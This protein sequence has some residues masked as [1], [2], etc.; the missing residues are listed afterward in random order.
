MFKATRQGLGTFSL[1]LFV[2]LLCSG[3][4]AEAAR[5]AHEGFPVPSIVNSI[6]S[7]AG[8][9]PVALTAT[10]VQNGALLTGDYDVFVIGLNTTFKGASALYVQQVGNFIAAGGNIVTEYS[11]AG[12]FLSAYSSDVQPLTVAATPQ[13]RLFDA[14]YH[15]G[16]Y[17]RTGMPI[18][19]VDTASPVV[20]GL[21][22]PF[23]DGSATEYFY[24][25]QTSDPHLH[26]VGTFVGTGTP[27]FPLGQNLP[28][29]VT[30]C[31]GGSTF[32][33]A[34]CDWSD[35]LALNGPV[36]TLFRNAVGYAAQGCNRPPACDIAGPY[37]ANCQ[38]AVSTVALNGTRSSDPDG[39]AMTFQWASDCPGASFD[40]PH[41]PT[42]V[43]SVDTAGSCAFSCN[44]TLTVNDGL[45]SSSCSTTVSFDD[46][47]AP[48]L[49]LNGAGYLVLEC[50]PNAYVEAGAT[51][52]D[53]C[54]PQVPVMVGG[55]HVA[56]LVPGTYLVTYDAQ[57]HCGNAAATVTRTVVMMDTIPPAFTRLPSDLTVECEGPAG[58]PA[59]NSAIAAFLSA[60]EVSDTCDPQVGITCDAPAIF[61]AGAT[62]VTWT[63]RDFSGN[64]V[65][66]SRT[67]EVV[68]RTPPE[69]VVPADMTLECP[70]DISVEANGSAGAF[71]RCGGVTVAWTDSFE[72]SCGDLGTI[73]RT[74]TATDGAGNVSTQVQKLKLVDTTPPVIAL[75]G[76]GYLVLECMV[77][78]YIEQGAMASDQ[79]DPQVVVA[80]GG[81]VVNTRVPATYL[82]TYDAQ[83]RCGNRAS[84]VQRVVEVKDTV[85]PTFSSLPGDLTVESEGPDGV[86]RT[87]PA[88]TSFLAMAQA[89]DTCDGS[90]PVVNDAPEVFPMADTW[91]NWTAR[92][93]SG[94]PVVASRLVRVVDTVP[95]A[96]V[97]PADV[98][99][100]C[101]H[102]TSVEQN[103]MATATD[104][105]GEATVTCADTRV[106]G[107]AGTVTVL[108]TFT[109]VD[110]SGNSTTSVQTIRVVD[111]TAP[112]V[113]VSVEPL[114]HGRGSA[115]H[116]S[117]GDSC[118]PA[119]VSAIV[120]TGCRRF[121]VADGEVVKLN[122]SDFNCRTGSG[123]V[124]QLI[125]TAVDGCGNTRSA[126]A[127]IEYHPDGTD[128]DP[129][130][131]VAFVRGDV[132]GDGR[133]GMADALEVVKLALG[134]EKTAPCWKA[135][136][137]NDDGKVRVDDAIFLV[138]VLC[139]GGCLPAPFPIV[140]LDPTPDSLGCVK[141]T[142]HMEHH[143]A[144][145]V[146]VSQRELKLQ[147][148]IRHAQRGK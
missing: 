8:H 35:N 27:G 24:W 87:N 53:A 38:G 30:G 54:D 136:D 111:T 67:C 137:A 146:K 89:S 49:A 109:A 91:V 121:P 126:S 138:T 5:V 43:L 139:S 28:C 88:V 125:V 107:C 110:P 134:H 92:D 131:T 84:Q 124:A 75:N 61:P 17:V 66:A 94:N 19:V 33:F 48:V 11:S 103:G 118:G 50:R 101:P 25:I 64:A 119:T 40:D 37:S 14:T 115:V 108:R 127:P 90:V 39:N 143:M 80:I 144:V 10:Q 133:I 20:A 141:Y 120:D 18:N 2:M 117:A 97:C 15:G 77:D 59:S 74:W 9:T 82:V 51:A 116:F 22:N 70:A 96:L 102:E 79:C 98:L 114:D 147:E 132:N 105:C 106:P 44:V 93:L 86:A 130:S 85:P 23:S 29:V 68:D 31:S 129:A 1:S 42:P 34:T 6:L 148:V 63:A 52:S 135:A 140:G 56:P 72:P 60:P 62:E 123:R 47:T 57:D 55:D 4:G 99:A 58:V 104:L 45:V 3:R 100:E 83:D 69:M 113:L 32:V 122:G 21:P 65:T 41:S 13:L 142:G 36:R 16:S 76:P 128:P 46:T 145:P 95:P 7:A 78:S 71:D 26:V 73:A 112:E 12:M 81:D